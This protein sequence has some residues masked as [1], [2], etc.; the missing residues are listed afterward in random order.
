MAGVQRVTERLLGAS[1]PVLSLPGPSRTITVEP[2][3]RPSEQPEPIE[4]PMPDTEREP[5]KEPEKLPS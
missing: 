4:E 2:I 1:D 5:V 3:E